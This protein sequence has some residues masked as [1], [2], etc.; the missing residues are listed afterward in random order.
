MEDFK[1]EMR[2]LFIGFMLF[3]CVPNSLL[4]MQSIRWSL[5][6]QA[7]SFYWDFFLLENQN[8]FLILEK[9]GAKLARDFSESGIKKHIQ[10]L[11]MN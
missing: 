11:Q 7:S 6:L 4:M 8:T 3:F 1:K 10:N 9:S 5:L 2:N